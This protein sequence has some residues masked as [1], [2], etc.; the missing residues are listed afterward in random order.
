MLVDSS[1][2]I[3]NSYNKR[4]DRLAERVI[5]GDIVSTDG[6]VLAT[7]KVAEDG[8]ETRQYPHDNMFAHSVGFST[9]G[10]SGL[11]LTANYYLLTSNVN[12]FERTKK[13]LQEEKNEGDTVVTTLNYKLQSTA[14][15]AIL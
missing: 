3:A 2:V 4:Q 10:K 1:T 5:R 15:N 11:E 12:I 9:Y 8:T 13:A 14:Y 6:E 7:T